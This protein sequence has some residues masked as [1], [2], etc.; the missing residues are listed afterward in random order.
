MK[1]TV[2]LFFILIIS[3][4]I[5][6]PIQLNATSQQDAD[7]NEVESIPGFD[8]NGNLIYH[9]KEAFKNF[10]YFSNKKTYSLNNSIVDFY[11]KAS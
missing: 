4:C 5:F 10:S 1:K 11:S 8:N 7:I 2:F 6:N 3:I 9:K